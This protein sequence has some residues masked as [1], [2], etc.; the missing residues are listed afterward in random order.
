MITTRLSTLCLALCLSASVWAA[1]PQP[2]RT[3]DRIIAVV[4]KS[5]ITERG[6]H[7]RV[8]QAKQNLQRQNVPA[9]SDNQLRAQVLERMISEEAQMQYAYNNGVRLDE[10]ELEQ[11][12]DRLAAANQLSPEAF[13]QKLK[14]QGINYQTF[15]EDVRREVIMQRLREREID[16][17]VNISDSEVDAFLN[18][19][20]NV[21][22]SEYRLA[23]ILIAVPETATPAQ[24]EQKAK[25]AEEAANR[26]KQGANFAQVAASYSDASDGL[27]GGELGWRPASRLPPPFVEVLNTLERNQTSRVLRS[28]SGFHIFKLLDKRSRGEAQLVEQV[29]ARHI[30]IK[31]SDSVGDKEA[32]QRLD[33]VQQRL[34]QGMSFVE[35]A[36]RYS[37]DGSASRGGDL[38]WLSPGDTVPEF[39]KVMYSLAPNKISA[40]VRSMFGWHLIEVIEKRRQDL[41]SERERAQIRQEL[42]ARKAEQQYQDWQRQLRDST[43]IENHLNDETNS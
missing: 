40:P 14:Q 9:P 22:R 24:V 8:L 12:V 17:K 33:E 42:K 35:A 38:G 3:V 5:V 1:Q 31:V 27:S 16:S 41:G 10:Q 39:E 20:V 7:D 18:S 6:L 30:L 32:K 25:R 2:V 28:A 34:A 37:E 23:H 15:R 26:L 13:R 29:H 11:T 36:R 21:G 43:Y 4:N 19:A